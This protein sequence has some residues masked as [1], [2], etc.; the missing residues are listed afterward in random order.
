ML[1]F[2]LQPGLLSADPHFEKTKLCCKTRKPST[3]KCFLDHL[4]CVNSKTA[5]DFSRFESYECVI[6]V[7]GNNVTSNVIY[8]HT[9]GPEGGTIG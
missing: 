6:A 7:P 1:I 8:V 5:D 9:F 3:A 2:Y 4:G